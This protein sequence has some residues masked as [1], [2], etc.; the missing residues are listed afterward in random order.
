MYFPALHTKRLTLQLQEISIGQSINLAAMPD[1]LHESTCTGFL[2]S[3][4]KSVKGIEDPAK[5][6]VQER[7]MAV[8]HY[9]AS[10]S[11]DGPDF[12]LG[13]GK[14]SDYLDASADNFIDEFE[15]GS[16]AGDEWVVRHLTGAMAE[17]I[18]RLSGEFELTGRLH[19]LLGGMA[20]QLVRKGEEIPEF[21][22]DALYDEWLLNRMRIFSNFP[23]SEFEL[24][25]GAYFVGLDA[26]HHLFAINFND[27]GIV[28]MPRRGT[29]GGLPPATF[30][31]SAY[32]SRAALDLAGKHDQSSGQSEPVHGDIDE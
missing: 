32:L 19:W 18:E 9:L 10:V 5:W 29:D 13:R 4:I 24:L 27:R 8:A 23:E 11:E 20:A 15:V 14:Y 16:F 25:M 7:N 6:T 22:S 30:P 26:L 21:P 1:H 17:S 2:R 31:A 28:V 3:A 12:S